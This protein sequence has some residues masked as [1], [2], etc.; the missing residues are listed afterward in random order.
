MNAKNHAQ[1]AEIIKLAGQKGQVTVATYM[2]GRGTDIKLGEGVRELGGLYVIGTERSESRRI[3]NQLRGRSGRQGD[4]GESRFFISLHDS[5]FK[6]FAGDKFN[7]AN[8]KM[9]EDEI[10]DLKF[11]SKLLDNTQKKVE[12]LNFD[13][14]KNLI[15]YDHVLSAQRELLYKERDIV[16]LSNNLLPILDSMV[17]YVVDDI[18]SKHIDHINPDF[19]DNEEVIKEVNSTIFYSE[20]LDIK[21]YETYDGDTLKRKLINEIKKFLVE[22]KKSLTDDTFNNSARNTIISNMDSAWTK[23][24]ETIARL[25]EGVNLR[26]YEQKSPLN[27]YIEDADLLFLDLKIRIANNVIHNVAKFGEMMNASISKLISQLN[28]APAQI[29]ELTPNESTNAISKIREINKQYFKYTMNNN[30]KKFVFTLL[31]SE[32]CIN[33]LPDLEQ[34]FTKN[35]NL[36]DVNKVLS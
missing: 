1:E 28:I 25:R 19:V 2:A 5:L 23:H 18:L 15:D 21:K 4:P 14:R 24:L 3:D 8:T 32:K 20:R 16:L 35:V 6:R 17:P 13:M 29:K 9:E 7:K 10:I 12:G 22:K 34:N 11:F 30:D 27:I 36:D 31:T 26:A 33:Y